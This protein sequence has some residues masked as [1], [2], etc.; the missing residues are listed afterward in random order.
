MLNDQ[1]AAGNDATINGVLSNSVGGGGVLK[2]G[3]GLL[4]VPSVNTYAGETQIAGG[5][6]L[7]TTASDYPWQAI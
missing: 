6:L 7:A 2:T 4:V 1:S 5:V 3:S